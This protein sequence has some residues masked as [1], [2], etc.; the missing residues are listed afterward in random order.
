M[1][2]SFGKNFN[3][4][5]EEAIGSAF[6]FKKAFEKRA[7]P[8]VQ[9]PWLGY[10]IVV[11][12][13][14]ESTRPARVAREKPLFEVMDIFSNTSYLDRWTILCQRLM[15]EQQYNNAALIYTEKNNEK[16]EYGFKDDELSFETFVNAYVGNLKGRMHEFEDRTNLQQTRL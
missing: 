4:R 8:F 5:A 11:Q 9:K 12:S 3:N 13:S 7:F 15:L 1:V 16:V 6:D 10:L 2:G 14:E